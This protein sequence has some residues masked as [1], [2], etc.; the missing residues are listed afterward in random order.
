MSSPKVVIVGIDGFDPV[1]LEQAMDAG[2]A[3]HCASLRSTGTF[4]RLG[5]T[6]PAQSPVAWASLAT[7]TNPGGHGLFDFIARDPVT[8][9][10]RLAILQPNTHNV[11]G[12]RGA[13]FNPVLHGTPFWEITSRSEIPTS[14]LKWPVNFPPAPVRGKALAGLGVPD[15]RTTLGRYTLFTTAAAQDDQEEKKGD[16]ITLV[17]NG[18]RLEAKLLGPRGATVP[19]VFQLR[20]E[21]GT[22]VLTVH[23]REYVLAMG[24]WSPWVQVVFPSAL[25][26]R[27][28]AMCRWYVVSTAPDV[29]I[30]ATALHVDPHKPAF[31]ISYPD[32]YAR[33]LADH[34][35]PY[36]TLGMPEETNGVIDDALSYDAYRL[37]I[38]DIQTEREAIFWDAL[39]HQQDGVFAFVFDT[40]DRA[41]HIFWM[42]KDTGHP[43]FREDERALYES[44]LG[45]F[46]RRMDA[47]LGKLVQQLDATTTLLVVSDH[48]FSTFRRAVHLNSWLREHGYLTVKDGAVGAPLFENVDWSKTRA[49]ALGFSSIYLNREGRERH[50]IVKNDDA[51]QVMQKLS[52][53]L[54]EA[55]DSGLHQPMVKSVERGSTLYSGPYAHEGPD[56][57]VGFRP[58]YRMS[59]QTAVGAA[60]EVTVED[61]IKK[62][63]GDHII[64]PSFVPG[65]LLGNRK[66][67]APAPSVLDLAPTVL[68]IFHLSDGTTMEGKDLFADPS[69]DGGRE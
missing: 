32:D 11:L 20:Q 54:I 36:H 47:L 65:V 35:G 12:R 22:V 14:V 24:K 51:E 69:K 42:T 26:Q 50:G 59:W 31:P 6:N 29:N 58:G 46:Y 64:D 16:L 13:M 25:G 37:L 45:D 7:G 3:P 52:A 27:I 40:I 10:P 44:V 1:V 53:E 57:V 17:R 67:T 18:N 8:H 34:V 61:N 63:S 41:Q 5:T 62:W 39:Q 60:P 56:M 68:S 43:L 21:D 48:G 33:E 28:A 4:S 9:L 15:I 23:E 55:Q 19:V 30:Y 49:Y 2:K 66:I 38:D